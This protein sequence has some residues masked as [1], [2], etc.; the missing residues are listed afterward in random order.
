MLYSRLKYHDSNLTV[1]VQIVVENQ[2]LPIE[3][4]LMAHINEKTL[5]LAAQFSNKSHCVSIVSVLFML[6]L[7]DLGNRG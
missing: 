7:C 3:F 6:S 5:Q 4:V 1:L 2:I